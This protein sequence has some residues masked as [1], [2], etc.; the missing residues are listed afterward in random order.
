MGKYVLALFLMGSF[1]AIVTWMAVEVNAWRRGR[2]LL[3][4]HQLTIRL[5]NGFLLLVVL[6]LIF[7]GRFLIRWPR[8]LSEIFYWLGI[9]VMVAIIAV[10][11]LHDW[12]AVLKVREEKQEQIYQDFVNTLKQTDRDRGQDQAER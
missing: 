5:V 2:Q 8:T 6:G 9:M 7:A 1:V 3:S 10:V 11:A 12:R 4:R